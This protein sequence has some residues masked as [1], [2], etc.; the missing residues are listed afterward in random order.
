MSVQ[1]TRDGYG[2]LGS[3]RELDRTSETR[4]NPGVLVTG[5]TISFAASDTINDS[6]NGL[7]AF[8]VGTR[9]RVSGGTVN[10]G[11]FLV[12]TV[13]AGSVTVTPAIIS[14]ESAGGMVTVEQ[15]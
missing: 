9:I 14:T 15:V 10:S 3:D 12:A 7:G 11:E 5:T 4:T 6:G 13:A 2:R 1:A 8:L